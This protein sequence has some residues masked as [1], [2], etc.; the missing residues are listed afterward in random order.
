MFQSPPTRFSVEKKTGQKTGH[1]LYGTAVNN[2][3]PHKS[4]TAWSQRSA[5]IVYSNL[6]SMVYGIWCM[7]YGIWYMVYSIVVID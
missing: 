6:Y 7:V 2:S 1:R 4:S 5:V 3:Q